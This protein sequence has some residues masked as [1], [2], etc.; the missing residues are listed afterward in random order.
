MPVTNVSMRVMPY[1][2]PGFYRIYFLSNSTLYQATPLNTQFSIKTK[3]RASTTPI[4]YNTSLYVFPPTP[5]NYL[6]PILNTSFLLA[7]QTM[8]KP[9]SKVQF[10]LTLRY[11]NMTYYND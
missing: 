7:N 5:P 11:D 3:Y 6:N 2:N 1:S 9:A 10:N 4:T 8:F